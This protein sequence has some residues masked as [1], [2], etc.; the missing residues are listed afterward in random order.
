MTPA[1]SQ[2]GSSSR[3][4]TVTALSVGTAATRDGPAAAG[5]SAAARAASASRPP[6]A[7]P[8]ART[9][10]SSGAART[11]TRPAASRQAVEQL[12]DRL[13]ALLGIGRQLLLD[14]LVLGRD[15]LP[16]GLHGRHDVR[17]DE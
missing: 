15:L 2:A 3:P 4:S 10:R 11:P 17:V 6:A 8:P 12:G 1:R 14:L 13:I 7:T 9:H 16:L 5:V